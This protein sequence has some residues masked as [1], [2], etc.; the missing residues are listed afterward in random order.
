MFALIDMNKD[1][2]CDGCQKYKPA[3]DFLLKGSDRI[4]CNI[5]RKCMKR[6]DKKI[7]NNKE[8]QKIIKETKQ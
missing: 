5:C 4:M 6:I 8:F 7:K 3:K 1:M 2:F